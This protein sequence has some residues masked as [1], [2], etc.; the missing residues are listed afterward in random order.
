MS[1]DELKVKEF[2]ALFR[3]CLN[4]QDQ[5]VKPQMERT[6]ILNHRGYR[7]ILHKTNTEKT[8]EKDI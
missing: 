2:K 3:T 6:I 5:Q 8:P 4:V 1:H 7:W